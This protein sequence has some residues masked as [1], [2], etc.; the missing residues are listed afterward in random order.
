MISRAKILAQRRAMLTTECALQRITLLGQTQS[1]GYVS[2]YIKTGS[3]L[4]EHLKHLPGWLAAVLVGL[5]IF[6][7]KRAV[8][9]ARNGLLLWQIWRALSSKSGEQ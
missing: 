8:P 2:D 6:I 1:L 9:L 7:P 5:V 4:V 3:N